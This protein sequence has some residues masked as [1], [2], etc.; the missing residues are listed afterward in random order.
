MLFCWLLIH[1]CNYFKVIVNKSSLMEHLNIHRNIFTN[2]IGP[3]FHICKDEFHIPVA[4]FLLKGKSQN[5]YEQMLKKNCGQTL[6]IKTMT[7]DFEHQCSSSVAGDIPRPK[8]NRTSLGPL[9]LGCQTSAT[10]NDCTIRNLS[11]L[12][13][14]P[15]MWT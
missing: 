1:H 13:I 15:T 8:S 6:N 3:T 14:A 9:R 5:N 4:F 12:A 2:Y 11:M 10:K 7:V